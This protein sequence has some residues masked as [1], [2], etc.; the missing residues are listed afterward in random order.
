VQEA[1]IWYIVISRRGL[2]GK[3]CVCSGSNV[4]GLI[5]SIVPGLR[6]QMTSY[7]TSLLLLLALAEAGAPATKCKTSEFACNNGRCVPLNKYCNIVNDCGDASDEPRYCTRES[8]KE[9]IPPVWMVKKCTHHPVTAAPGRNRI[10][11]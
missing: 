5:L 10:G 3:R 8:A 4:S 7:A 2:N 6:W 1:V 11:I 9:S